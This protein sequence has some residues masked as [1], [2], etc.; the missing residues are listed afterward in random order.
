[1]KLPMFCLNIQAPK[2]KQWWSRKW[3]HFLQ[4]IQC[5]VGLQVYFKHFSQYQ[6]LY[7]KFVATLLYINFIA[8]ALIS[9]TEALRLILYAEYQFKYAWME[10]NKKTGVTFS[11]IN[12]VRTITAKLYSRAINGQNFATL[13]GSAFISYIYDACREASY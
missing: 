2:K 9:M 11:L 13:L 8:A 3:K 5:C 4:K 12:A 7:S 1:M 6:Y 10:K